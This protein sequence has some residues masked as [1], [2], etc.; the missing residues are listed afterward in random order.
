M[1][2]TFILEGKIKEISKL[3]LDGNGAEVMHILIESERSYRNYKGEFDSDEIRIELYRHYALRF[4]E[5]GKVGDMIC[6]Q[7]RIDAL[8]QKCKFVAEKLT[9]F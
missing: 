8:S 3:K 1:I 9:V 7:G 4:S 2:N 6:V 5:I